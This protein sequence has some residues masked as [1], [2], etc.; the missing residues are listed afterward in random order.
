MG[1]TRQYST[2]KKLRVIIFF[3]SGRLIRA[4][5]YTIVRWTTAPIGPRERDIYREAETAGK[6]ALLLSHAVAQP[7]AL[8][9]PFE[10][11]TRLTRTMLQ[12]LQTDTL[13]AHGYRNPTDADLETMKHFQFNDLNPLHAKSLYYSSE[14]NRTT[15]AVCFSI[16]RLQPSLHLVCPKDVSHIR[17]YITVAN[18][19]FRKHKSQVESVYHEMIP[20]HSADLYNV[21]MECCLKPWNYQP[22]FIF[23]GVE[24]FC[25]DSVVS[26][27]YQEGL[28]D[29]LMIAHISK[30]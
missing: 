5:A 2:L 28:L 1:D 24:M 18:T 12:V 21:Q 20:A 27:R 23:F 4:W 13:N 26:P 8:I 15:G 6:A 14:I 19:D 29:M 7:L 16:R 11:H 30:V 10:L 25:G 17:L 3:K 9:K 22:V